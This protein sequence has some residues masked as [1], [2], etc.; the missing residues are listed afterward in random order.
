[1]EQIYDLYNNLDDRTVLVIQIFVAVFATAL[2]SLL[3][4]KILIKIGTKFEKTKNLWDDVLLFSI[5]KPLRLFIW[6]YGVTYAASLA[7]AE[8]E[9]QYD[10]LFSKIHQVTFILFISWSLLR[11]INSF[12][13]NYNNNSKLQDRIDE[14]TLSAITKLLNISVIITSFLVTLQTLG[15]SI[16]AVLAF[17]GVGGLAVGLAAKDMLSNFFGAFIIY[18]DKPFK[19]GDWI[20][21]PDKSIEGVVEKIGWRQTIVRTFDKR[22]LYVPNSVFNSIIVENPSR[23]TNRR[24][25][26]HYGVRY[27]DMSSV[28]NIVLEVE[29]MLKNHA[30]IDTNQTLMVNLNNFSDSTVDFF[31]YTFTKTTNWEEF[32]QI[33]QEIMLNISNIIAA[34]G[35]EF[36]YPTTTLQLPEDINFNQ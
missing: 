3:S 26:E 8:M 21:S 31:V 6:V 34:N 15:F 22:P 11:F 1:M 29:N 36:A 5:R 7:L 14:T 12:Q 28:A 33:K 10:D 18:M 4:R 32:H 16:S 17:G 20:R 35:A 30:E 9:M 24:I 25:Y 23:M 27:D 2:I 19:V 13:K